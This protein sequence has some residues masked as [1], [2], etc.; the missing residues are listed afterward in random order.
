MKIGIYNEAQGSTF[1]GSERCVAVLAEAL[2]QCHEVEIIHHVKA[3]V[4]ADEFGSH[5]GTNLSKVKLRYVAPEPYFISWSYNL[6]RRYLD[7]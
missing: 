2:S 5:Y 6:R 3:A 1:G 7:A 4:D